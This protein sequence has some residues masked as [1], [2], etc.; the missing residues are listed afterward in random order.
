MGNGRGRAGTRPSRQ[1]CF[2]YETEARYHFT[3]GHKWVMARGLKE[4]FLKLLINFF[5]ISVGC[6]VSESPHPRYPGNYRLFKSYG[7]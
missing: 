2:K 3:A 5:S 1:E 7:L 6:W 4:E